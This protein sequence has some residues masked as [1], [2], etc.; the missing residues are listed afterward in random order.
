[1]LT[2]LTVRDRT[3]RMNQQNDQRMLEAIQS[4]RWDAKR[5]A[6]NSLGWL[7][8]HGH[9]DKSFGVKETVGFLLHRMIVD[10]EF[11]SSI[12]WML[13][14]WKTWADVGG[15]KRAEYSTVRDNQVLFA[16]AILLVSL[17]M[18]AA[19]TTSGTLSA[20]LQE[21]LHLWKS[22]RLG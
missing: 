2:A 14:M 12:S 1:M 18:E 9:C 5:I 20:D 16:Q 3:R 6:A 7:S 19:T 13:D 10:A 11:A 4:P 21:C 17:I 22:I 15:M 8:S